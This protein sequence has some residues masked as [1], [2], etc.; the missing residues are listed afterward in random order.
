MF[1]QQEG[2]AFFVAE[3]ERE[4]MAWGGGASR[5][6]SGGMARRPENVRR[7]ERHVVDSGRIC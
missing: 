4:S 6:S 3:R 2:G 7:Y 1:L 5:Q